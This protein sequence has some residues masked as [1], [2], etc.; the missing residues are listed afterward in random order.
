LRQAVGGT[1]SID[2]FNQVTIHQHQALFKL[3]TRLPTTYKGFKSR[4]VVGC[5]HKAQRFR[6][7]VAKSNTI[8]SWHHLIASSIPLK[9]KKGN[10]LF[11]QQLVHRISPPN[12]FCP[13]RP[14][15]TKIILNVDMSDD[16][17]SSK[18]LFLL[19]NCDLFFTSFNLLYYLRKVLVDEYELPEVRNCTSI[20]GVCSLWTNLMVPLIS[21]HR[22]KQNNNTSLKFQAK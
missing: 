12:L 1:S 16:G 8:L 15:L 2:K 4:P 3:Q 7:H 17:L 6:N 9:A 10:L 14:V 20:A 18:D 22:I 21:A 13:C 19:S 11:W 5:L